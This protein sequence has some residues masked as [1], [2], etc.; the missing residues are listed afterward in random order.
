MIVLTATSMART[1]IVAQQQVGRP[2]PVQVLRIHTHRRRR[3]HPC[4]RLKA[5]FPP[6]Y[7]RNQ[8]VLLFPNA[9]SKEIMPT[10]FM[11]TKTAYPSAVISLVVHVANSLPLAQI[12]ANQPKQQVTLHPRREL[13]L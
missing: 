2:V 12:R 10:V 13:Q 1:V 8:V 9:T 7:R 3:T 4:H 11:E 5:P 6:Q